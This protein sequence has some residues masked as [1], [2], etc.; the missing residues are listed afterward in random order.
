MKNL[1]F[2]GF[3]V[4]LSICF[5]TACDPLWDVN[6]DVEVSN[7]SSKNLS[8]FFLADPNRPTIDTTIE[9]ISDTKNNRIL[10]FKSLNLG[11][12]SPG[13]VEFIIYNKSDSKI[14]SLKRSENKLY[15]EFVTEKT[16]F[17]KGNYLGN[18]N[19]ADI[20]ISLIITD[21]LLSK[22]TKNTHLT[23]SIFGL[24]KY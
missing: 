8:V 22:M 16:S 18:T 4:F 1:I 7:N 24:K 6:V 19:K 11:N 20:N 10:F 13:P 14:L 17:E 15:N 12:P 2:I 23:D 5:F 9:I 3:I 21:S